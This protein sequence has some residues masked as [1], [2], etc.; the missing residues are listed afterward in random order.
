MSTQL[1][2]K[3]KWQ[4]KTTIPR[5]SRMS[6]DTNPMVMEG[7]GFTLHKSW[8]QIVQ[9]NCFFRLL[10]W[11]HSL[12][13]SKLSHAIMVKNAWLLLR[14]NIR[15]LIYQI[16]LISVS[17][18]IFSNTS[19][20]FRESYFKQFPRNIIFFNTEPNEIKLELDCLIFLYSEIKLNRYIWVRYIKIW[21]YHFFI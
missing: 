7:F 15:W 18:Q 11:I 14:K 12:G 17:T 13:F 9:Y 1:E 19:D 8:H 6:M 10:H 16:I 21:Y 3:I 2:N 20:F 4:I 5:N